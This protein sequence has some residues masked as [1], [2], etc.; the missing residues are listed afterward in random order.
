MPARRHEGR[1][2]LPEV[3]RSI[4]VPDGASLW[5]KSCWPSPARVSWSPSATWTPATGP[6]TSPAARSTATR[7]SSVILISNL[8]AILLQ[9]LCVKLGVVTGRDLAQACRDHY[10][11]PV[12]WI[13]WVLCELA[14]AACDLAE[15]VGSAI[16]LQA[17]LRHPARLGLRHHGARCAGRALPAKQGLPLRRGAGHHADPDHRRLLRRGADLRRSRTSAGSSLGFV[18]PSE[19]LHNQ[20]MLYVAIGILGATVMPHN[21]YLHSSIVQTRKFERTRRGQSRG[22]QVC[23]AS[24]RRSR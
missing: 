16:G 12:V 7:C 8:M 17:A 9:H 13:L 19:I 3:F 5:R 23:D 6:P 10:S 2:S 1:V 20:E 4:R 21:L 18:P 22:D 14:I 15:V 24:I 11:R